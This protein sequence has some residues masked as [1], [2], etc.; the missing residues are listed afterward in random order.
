MRAKAVALLFL[1]FFFESA[2][3]VP[4][5]Q[6]EPVN[7]IEIPRVGFPAFTAPNGQ[8]KV[9]LLGEAGPDIQGRIENEFTVVDLETILVEPGPEPGK[10]SVLFKLQGG[11]P[12]LYDLVISVGGVE[13]REPNSVAVMEDLNPPFMV[14][15][16]S[17]THYDNRLG[18]QHQG[19]QFQ[20]HLWLINFLSPDFAIVTGDVCNNPHEVIF[21]GLYREMRE[22]D[23]PI[24]LVPGNHDH[25]AGRQPF[26][27]Y[28]APSNVSLE[29]GPVHI[30]ILDTGPGSLSG[31]ISPDQLSWL[32]EDL[33]AT[34]ATVKIVAMHHPP[35]ALENRSDANVEM[36]VDIL[37]EHGVSLVISGHMHE[38]YVF[39]E[40]LLMV[41][42]PNSYG[43]VEMAAE[44]ALPGYRI[45]W[46]TE[47]SGFKWLGGVE[48]PI[49][50]DTFEV[51]HYQVNDGT[52]FGF[53]SKIVNKSPW[54]LNGTLK[55]RLKPGEVKVDGGRLLFVRESRLGYQ[56][57]YVAVTVD[58][59]S[60]RL[61]RVWV[62]EDSEPPRAQIDAEAMVRPT[63]VI[64]RLNCTVRDAVLGVADVKAYVSP[65]NATWSEV[66][67]LRLD[68]DTFLGTAKL[69]PESGKGYIRLEA[70]DIEGRRSTSYFTILWA[71]EAE[72]ERAEAP[73]LTWVILAAVAGA[74][75]AAL[76]TKLRR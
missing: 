53:S 67:L 47:Q 18:Q 32:E 27:K 65:D 45:F 38:N 40:P 19:A 75:L 25:A 60:E 68:E 17:D 69:A 58:P 26:V 64:V 24:I 22:F 51:E 76:A 1:L 15:W 23:V 31:S 52:A 46:I 57:A 50:L 8:L 10:T 7:G 70:T 30:V 11:E 42:N 33:S 3:A 20:R 4:A 36:L 44:K 61:V 62:T 13:R 63:S 41:T 6:D 54:P 21:Q 2:Q 59:Q 74:V 48:K 56:V 72:R 16:I 12:G 29:V 43:M 14:F 71:E 5:G 66:K 55:V 39:Y 73:V 34:N 49:V 37:L 35:F 9:V 28:L